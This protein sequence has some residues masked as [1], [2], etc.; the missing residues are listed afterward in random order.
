LQRCPTTTLP[1]CF[2]FCPPAA[3][4]LMPNLKLFQMR[5]LMRP[6]QAPLS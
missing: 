4:D 6:L 2:S 3:M 5:T 1:T